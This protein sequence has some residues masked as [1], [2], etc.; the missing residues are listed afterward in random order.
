MNQGKYLQTSFSNPT[1]NVIALKDIEPI[2][3]SDFFR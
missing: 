1:G 2:L 3:T